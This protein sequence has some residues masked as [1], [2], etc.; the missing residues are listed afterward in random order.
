VLR[1]NVNVRD[2]G[3]LDLPG[4]LR[5]TLD[6]IAGDWTREIASRTRSGRDVAGRA[7]RRKV[8]GTVSRL[9]DSGAMLASLK[10]E[11]DDRGFT[12]AP[13]G[14]RNTVV[15]RT[16]QRT[17]REFLG[18]DERQ[19]EDAKRTIVDALQGTR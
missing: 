14:A 3:P 1:V 11:V 17:R 4:D 8:D 7:L 10:A 13:T 15:A 2:S 9:H 12:I 18:A 19:I 6:S 5:S 16:H